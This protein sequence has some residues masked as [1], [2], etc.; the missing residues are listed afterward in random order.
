MVQ[1]QAPRTIRYI[2]VNLISSCHYF[3]LYLCFETFYFYS[4]FDP[5]YLPYTKEYRK[6]GLRARV[7]KGGKMKRSKS[8]AR[9]QG[10][11]WRPEEGD[12]S[13]CSKKQPHNE[14]KRKHFFHEMLQSLCKP[15][16]QN[17]AFQINI[18][19]S[20]YFHAS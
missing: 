2:F 16:K 18:C 7:R 20:S 17:T 6:S 13:S 1:V 9:A 3:M 4:Y 8:D 14:A 19:L 10:K 15:R 12:H 11:K 5:R